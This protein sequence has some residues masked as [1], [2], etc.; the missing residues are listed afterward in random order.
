MKILKRALLIIF[1]LVCIFFIAANIFVSIF[2]KKI[3]VEQIQQ[4]LKVSA[5]LEAVSVSFP[6]SINLKN[7]EVGDFFKARNLSVSP[8]LLGFFAGKIVLNK[9]VLLEPQII[10][11]QS[12]SGQLNLPQMENNT[13]VSKPT[14]EKGSIDQQEKGEAPQIYLASLIIRDG[15]LSFLDKKVNP[16]GCKIMLAGVDA[17]ISKVAF[18]LTSLKTNFKISGDFLN[19]DDKKIGRINFTGWLDYIPKDMDGSLEIKDLDL[20][21]FSPYYG[22]FISSR[23]LKSATLNIKTALKSKSNDLNILTN[24]RLSNLT[25]VQDAPQESDLSQLDLTKNALDFFTDNKGNLDLEFDIDTKL[26]N[27]NISVAQ[28]E[29][30]ILKAAGKNLA[31]QSPETL[32]QKVSDNIENFKSIGKSLEGLFKAKE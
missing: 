29:K 3:I 7:L 14:D 10:L 17:D 4:N 16:S 8:N 32:I 22:N 21:Y 20:T 9:L 31:N 28:L 2:A 18:P 23:K 1:I 26:D 13:G 24:F 15:R 27:P 6:L 5:K 30:V 25:Y 11:E 19:L 12:A